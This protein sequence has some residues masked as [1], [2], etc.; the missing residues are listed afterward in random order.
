MFDN[1]D[2]IFNLSFSVSLHDKDK[3]KYTVTINNHSQRTVTCATGECAPVPL[4]LSSA[5][6]SGRSV[7][8][9]HRERPTSAK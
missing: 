8:V 3:V 1:S 2:I 6:A 5:A 4:L 9:L 7:Q